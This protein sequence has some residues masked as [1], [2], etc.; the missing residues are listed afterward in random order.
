MQ[1]TKPN[2]RRFPIRLGLVSDEEAQAFK[3]RVA[4]LETARDTGYPWNRELAFWVANLSDELHAK[5]AKAE[6]VEGRSADTLGVLWMAFFRTKAKNKPGSR[7]VV[8]RAGKDLLAFFGEDCSA[9]SITAA[10]GD[11]WYAWLIE[12]RNLAKATRGKT[13]RHVKEFWRMLRR[14][15]VVDAL[16]FDHLSGATPANPK[17]KLFI[18]RPTI[19]RV[20]EACPDLRWRLILALTRFGGLRCPSELAALHFSDINWERE[21]FVVNAR[22]TEHFEHGGVRV[23]PIFPELR[24]YLVEAFE[25][26]EPGADVVFPDIT[27]DTNLG[28]QLERIIKRAGIAPWPATFNNLRASRITELLDEHPI[29]AVTTWLGNSPKT[30]LDHYAMVRE[31]HFEKA[32]QKAVHETVH[33]GDILGSI[34]T[35]EGDVSDANPLVKQSGS[36]SMGLH[37]PSDVSSQIARVGFEPTLARF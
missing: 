11:L 8:E 2:G 33:H 13:V 21:R 26:A 15:G 18:D 12:K 7:S 35:H 30:A 22:K 14:D 1:T 6:L 36:A 32:V 17:R 4:Q 25:Q 37:V 19:D 9:R 5:L 31:E 10:H 27:P 16:P 20:M 24:P 3:V 23:C 28:T 29:K 34:K